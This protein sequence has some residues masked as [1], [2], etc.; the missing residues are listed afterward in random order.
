MAVGTAT[1]PESIAAVDTAARRRA[2][3][4]I[5][6]GVMWGAAISIVVLLAFFIGYLFYLGW[7]ALSWHF[8]TAPPEEI[9]AG[10][11]IGPEIFN[12]FY[13][14]ILTLIFTTPIAMASGIYL[15]EYARPG[16]FTSVVQF[17]AESL[18][19]LP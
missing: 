7:S 8:L 16:I 18:E 19:T 6:T 11:G 14:L 1:A 13:I 3:D 15:Q 4:V 5:M 10:G 12:S 17:C 9:T 2:V